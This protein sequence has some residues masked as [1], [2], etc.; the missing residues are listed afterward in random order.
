MALSKKD[1]AAFDG[2]REALYQAKAF[3]FTDPVPP[4]LPVPKYGEPDTTGWDF[5]AYTGHVAEAW[6]GVAAHGNGP[7]RSSKGTAIQQGRNLYSTKLLA[8]RALR[9]AVEME[10]AKKLACIDRQIDIEGGQHGTE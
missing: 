10:C 7:A 4:D 5:N 1:Q 6:S 9:R 2:L 3:R 8:L